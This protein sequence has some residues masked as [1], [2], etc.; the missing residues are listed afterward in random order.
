MIAHSFIH[1]L[2]QTSNIPPSFIKAGTAR[3][4]IHGI[5]PEWLL[6]SDE[7]VLAL[8]DFMG[9][10][11]KCDISSIC[12]QTLAERVVVCWVVFRCTSDEQILPFEPRQIAFEN[13]GNMKSARGLSV[14]E[15]AETHFVRL[16][17]NFL[18]IS[19]AFTPASLL[20]CLYS[21]DHHRRLFFLSMQ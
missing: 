14:R 9:C 7:E 2:I 12:A 20:E 16:G 19:S 17:C 1:S 11:K 18:A 21:I 10:R 5:F 3:G 4:F 13:A 8:K 15:S 6:C